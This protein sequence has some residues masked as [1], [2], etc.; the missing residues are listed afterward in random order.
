MTVFEAEATP[1]RSDAQ[2]SRPLRILF[3]VAHLGSL[4]I[5]DTVI[6]ELTVRGHSIRIIPE[7][8]KD[9]GG[10]E[11]AAR[12]T[13]EFPT[14][15]CGK[16]PSAEQSVW[17]L[18][19]REIR[20]LLDYFR[21]SD[22]SYKGFPQL[23]RRAGTRLAPFVRKRLPFLN[24]F[25]RWAVRILSASLRTIERAA[26]SQIPLLEFLRQEKPDL[27]LITPLLALGSSQLE[28]LRASK[29]LGLRTALCVASWDH[30]SSKAVLRH[31]PD[32]IFV[33]NETQ[34]TEA[35]DLHG[36]PRERV[37]VTGAQCF[38]HWFDRGSELS[39]EAFCEKVGLRPE[40]PF[41]VYA[42]SA[43]FPGSP[44]EA[45]FVYKW[46]ERIR[47][48]TFPQLR[49]AGLLVRPHPTRMH[50]WNDIDLT[51]FDNVSLWGSV[52]IDDESRSD[53]FESLHHSHAVVGLNTS[54]FLEAGIVGRP[55][56]TILEPEFWDNQEGTL[57]FH[58]LLNVAGGLLRSAR[59]FDEHLKQ[60]SESIAAP[61]V[62]ARQ[63]H[64]FVKA[65]IRPHGVEVSATDVFADGV[66][67]LGNMA[68]PAPEA[69]SVGS[70]VLAVLLYPFA[71]RVNQLFQDRKR[72]RDAKK[73]RK[74]RK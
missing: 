48:A 1:V 51:G 30:L 38:D 4:R 36:V 32:R 2:R 18:F 7:T 46:I 22:E 39:R 13:R 27:V 5:Y 63:S 28:V 62:A 52:P 23:R 60:L 58:Y 67:S 73:S 49:S 24:R 53:Y 57:H 11:T 34:R 59:S 55:V 64:D 25:P 50:L 41:L 37:V 42:C 14:V 6:Q 29:T 9:V 71:L 61:S 17:F 56:H 12:L 19:V 72:K 40:R 65:F 8:A 16:A 21:Y 35:M 47:A 33:W 43:L 70:R 54:A 3:S 10:Y 44:S 45:E 20:R 69:R 31:H 15:T 66:E 68:S 26:P 74:K